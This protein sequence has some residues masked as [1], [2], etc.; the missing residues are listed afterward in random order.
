M[1][2]L[3]SPR[4]VFGVHSV[5][6]Y[7]RVDR[8]PYGILKVIGSASL[9]FSSSVEQLY[10]GSQRFAWAAESKTFASSMDCKV[11]AYPGFLFSLFMGATVVE[12]AGEALASVTALV[13]MKGTSVLQAT[14][15]IASV[16]ITT[17]NESNVKFAQYVAVATD[18]TH[19]DIYMMSDVDAARGSTPVS[20][21][22][23]SLKITATP[24]AITAATPV[25]IP[26]TGLQLV[27]GSGTIAL[28]AGDTAYFQ[29]RPENTKSS[30][31]SIGASTTSMPAFGAVLLAQKRATAEMCEIEAFNCIAEGFPL[32]MDEMKFSETS[33]KITLLYDSVQDKVAKIRTVTPI[34]FN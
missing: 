32:P 7:S 17:G 6:P 5:S 26:N 25:V 23:D 8:T 20:F 2:G 22:N 33:C 11:K 14:T 21:Q 34:T 29:S 24:L 28:V 18:A 19:V 27:G 16:G 31:I 13:N 12:N 3:G 4:I 1:S 9:A 10:G 15:G 30:D